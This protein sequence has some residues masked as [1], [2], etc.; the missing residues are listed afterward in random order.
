LIFRLSAAVLAGRIA[1]WLCRVRGFRGSSMPGLVA[2]KAD[3]DSL[4]KL[5]AQVRKGTIV[6][7][8]TNGKTTTA[9]M[10]TGVLGDAGYKVVSNREGANMI[11][12]VTSSFVMSSGIDGK[13]DCDYAVIEIDEASMPGVLKE[14]TPGVVVLTNFFRDQLDRY[15]ELDKVIGVIRDSLREQKN[16]VMVL[17]A[18]DPLVAQFGKTTGLPAFFYGLAG[19]EHSRKTSTQMREA[20]FCPFCGAD[21]NYDFYHY[22]QLGTYNCL[23]CSFERP[24][25]RV[26]ALDAG[27]NGEANECRLF[28]DRREVSLS[29]QVQGLYNLYNALAAFSACLQL[30]IDV[31][32]ILKSLNNYQ[33]VTGRME[34]FSY[35]EKNVYLS[36]VKNPIGF[37]E[38]LAALCAAKGSKDV[39]IAVNDNDAD[40]KDISWLW[41]VDFEMLAS[42]H[43]P[44]RKLICSGVRGEEMAL[45]LKYAGVPV[46][47]IVVNRDLKVAVKN[48]LNGS[49]G[50][51]YLFSTYTALWNVH[52][53]VKQLADKED[54]DAQHLS[55]VS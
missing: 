2:R 3:P 1:S 33:P 43:R 4:R 17:N 14:I 54:A 10:I 52:K 35:K 50:G 37:S 19:T 12:G 11:G 20:R 26:E 16:V 21:L 31:K 44:I 30:G 55:S 40:G 34:K 46:E 15:W 36:L 8:G 48:A 6:V 23:K 25:P 45:R 32:T 18:D 7:S 5:A 29:I 13:I 27:V 38:V 42:D 9:N 51:A 53:I 41:D 22:G 47:K 39:L 28:F 49:A 24:K